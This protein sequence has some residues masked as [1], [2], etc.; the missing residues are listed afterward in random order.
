MVGKSDVLKKDIWTQKINPT[1]IVADEAS[2]KEVR[3][4]T[5]LLQTLYAFP[6]DF[7]DVLEKWVGWLCNMCNMI[8][9]HRVN[10]NILIYSHFQ[11][12]SKDKFHCVVNVNDSILTRKKEHDNKY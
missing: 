7:L 4:I 8:L 9:K 11:S 5:T 10:Q 6:K 1:S 12:Y 2:M 3:N